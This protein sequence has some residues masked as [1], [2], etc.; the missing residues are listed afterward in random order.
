MSF[1]AARPPEGHRLPYPMQRST[2]HLQSAGWRFESAWR[3]F[4][5]PIDKQH[6]LH[7]KAPVLVPGHGNSSGNTRRYLTTRR[8]EIRLRMGVYRIPKGLG[9]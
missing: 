7:R 8:T 9:T 3:S 5:L 2:N 6:T 4:I 1:C